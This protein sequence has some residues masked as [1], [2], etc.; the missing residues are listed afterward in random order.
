MYQSTVYRPKLGFWLPLVIPMALP[1]YLGVA[2]I[3][4]RDYVLAVASLAFAG[5]I[6]GYNAT[7]RL[8]VGNDI[9]FAR[10][11]R[12]LWRI[13]PSGVRVT[14]GRAGEVPILPAFIF[15]DRDGVKGAVPKGMFSVAASAELR[16][17]V[18][19]RGGHW[20]A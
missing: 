1:I 14:S 5:L 9:C 3:L 13:E 11:G 19:R 16:S 8:I 7:A 12:T 4:N 2:L 6:V 20:C 10:F 17:I 18:E 15:A